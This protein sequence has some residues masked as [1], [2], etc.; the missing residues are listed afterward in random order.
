MAAIDSDTSMTS[1]TTARLR[2]TRM[3][4]VGPAIAVVSSVSATTDPLGDP[5]DVTPSILRELPGVWINKRYGV[6]WQGRAIVD[7][8]FDIAVPLGADLSGD[9]RWIQRPGDPI[10]YQRLNDTVGNTW[11]PIVIIQVK[12]SNLGGGEQP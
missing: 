12:A 9:W 3:S 10:Y 8:D 7:Y 1:M 11:N 4:D 5:K 6:A 2:G